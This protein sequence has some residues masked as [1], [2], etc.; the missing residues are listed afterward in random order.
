MSI[1]ISADS[2]CDLSAK[3]LATYHIAVTPLYV[4]FDGEAKRDGVDCT[5]ADILAFTEKTGRLCSTAAVS[6]GD[7]GDFFA[8]A[9]EEYE[10]V[11]HFTISAEMS[12]CYQNACV[13][14]GEF[15]GRVMVVD[16]RS[17][18]AGTGL[19]VLRAAQ[20]RDA[21]LGAA[22]IYENALHRRE[23]VSIFFIPETLDYLAK[24]GRCSAVAAL[25]ANLLKI[26]PCIE[27]VNGKM[28]V[29]KKYRGTMGRVLK[30]MLRDHLQ[31]RDDLRRDLVLI[32]TNAEEAIVNAVKEE[33]RDFGSVEVCPLGAT[34]VCHC[35]GNTL[36]IVIEYV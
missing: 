29:G 33:L 3:L 20:D 5:G 15:G 28:E 23:K 18:S 1:L 12:S 26:R 21:G 7:Y 8:K 19:Q 31:G 25:G 9:C 14:A 35:G 10:A 4:V 22:D 17:V 13:A 24:G 32:P 34:V 2:T 30:E 11:I 27:T 16:S 36:G 6:I